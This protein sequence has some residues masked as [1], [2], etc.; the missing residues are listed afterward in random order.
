MQVRQDA[1]TQPDRPLDA[2][3]KGAQL[4][5]PIRSS[6]AAGDTGSWWSPSRSGRISSWGAS[7]EYT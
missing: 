3:V 7:G 2:R 5:G 4:L 1:K 6:N